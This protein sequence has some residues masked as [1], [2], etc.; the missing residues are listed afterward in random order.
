MGKNRKPVAL[1]DGHLLALGI[2]VGTW[3]DITASLRI[4]LGH[5]LADDPEAVELNGL[6]GDLENRLSTLRQSYATD[7]QN[8]TDATVAPETRIG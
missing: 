2:A 8:P 4:I 3:S 5:V 1:D 7:R 6:L